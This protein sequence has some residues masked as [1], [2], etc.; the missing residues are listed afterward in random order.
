MNDPTEPY[1]RSRQA[2]LNQC[3]YERRH[4]EALYGTV[5]DTEQLTSEFHV[6]GFMAPFVIVQRRSDDAKGSLEFQH[7]PRFYFNFQ[8]A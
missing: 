5:W 2:E 4:L 8:A 1:R 7:Y 6:H 3:G